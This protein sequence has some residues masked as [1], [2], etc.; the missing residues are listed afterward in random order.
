[1]ALT[2]FRWL[3]PT[4]RLERPARRRAFLPR[5]E[6]L[7]DRRLPTLFTL[8]SLAD[9]GVGSLRQATLDAGATTGDQTIRFAAGVTGTLQLAAALPDLGRSGASN[10][11]LEGPGAGLVTVRRN[12]G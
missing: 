11:S 12:S 6:A 7:E 2:L 5:L 3:N 9:A 4:T 1:M 10:L 8:T